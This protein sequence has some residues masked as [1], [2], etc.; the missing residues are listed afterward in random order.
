MLAGGVLGLSTLIRHNP[1]FL[2][3]VIMLTALAVY[4]RQWKR[5]LAQVSLFGLALLM[6]ISP[7][8]YYSQKTVGTPWYFMIPLRGVI[9]K[10]R[11]QPELNESSLTPTTE[12]TILA[13]SAGITTAGGMVF[14][15][16]GNVLPEMKHSATGIAGVV[17]I[18]S[19]HLYN[20]L[21]G[22]LLIL[23]ETWG[24]DDLD[25]TLNDPDSVWQGEWTEGVSV[26]MVVNVFLLL[27][28]IATSWK[29]LRIGGIV[30]FIMYVGYIISLSV[31]RT[32]G[33]RYLVPIDWI[34]LLYYAVGI[35]QVS[36]WVTGIL[37]IHERKIEK[38]AKDST[39]VRLW[40]VG[41]AGLFLVTGM[42]PF[43]QETI[44][45][46][47]PTSDEAVLPSAEWMEDAGLDPSA[48]DEFLRRDG[49][50]VRYGKSVYPRF[51]QWKEGDGLGCYGAR[52]YPRLVFELIGDEGT[53]CVTLPYAN[54]TYD[55]QL[56][57]STAVVLGCEGGGD[58]VVMFPEKD[59]AMVRFTQPDPPSCPLRYPICADNRNCR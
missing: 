14:S 29:K 23:P 17:Q 58:W 40:I 38:Q 5:L 59:L 51:Y 57:Y 25:H 12:R 18:L 22:S 34:V 16:S 46:S 55:V 50:V 10:G 37:P 8:M 48:I 13:S 28:G 44:P 45:R 26:L 33:G 56:Q 30:P 43:V 6:V 9:W 53:Q 47:L 21:R 39:P 31:A 52:A 49:A 32:S 35:V 27:I 24:A 3:P 42:I 2:A 7:W 54:M 19:A 41:I 15:Q 20:N 36:V 11:L 1:W 4:R